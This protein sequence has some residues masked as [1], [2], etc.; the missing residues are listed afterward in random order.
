MG[1]RSQIRLGTGLP[2]L[3]KE[4][5]KHMSGLEE[6][7]LRNIDACKQ[8]SKIT[9]TSLGPNGMNKLVVN[10][11]D[12]LFVTSDTG[13]IVTELEVNHPAAKMVTMAAKMQESEVGDGTNFVV[14]FAGELLL[15]AEELLRQGIHISEIISGFEKAAEFAMRT[16]PELVC[17]SV[18]DVTDPAQLQQAVLPVMTAK[19]Y[20]YHKALSE[21]VSTACTKAMV[22]SGSRVS[23]NVDNVRVAKLVGG[24]VRDTTV[25]RGM[26]V[27]R[28]AASMV[29]RV[30]DAKVAVFGVG[31]EVSGTETKSTV[32]LRSA[33]E[34]LQYSKGEEK[35]IEDAVK[36]IADAGA[37]V[38]ISG[39]SISEMALHFVDK[40]NLMV[41]K[42]TSKFELRRLCRALGAV[43][44]VRLGPPMP[45]EM[46]HCHVVEEVE[47]GG[48]RVVVFRQED[49]EDGGQIAT[50]VLRGSTMNLLDDLERAVDDGVN[51]AKTAVQD[52][53]LVPGAG[54]TELELAHRVGEFAAG[55]PGL[56]QYAIRKFGEALEVVPR[57]LAVNAG[58]KA[59]EVIS[60]LYA[61]HASGK[62]SVGVDV[63]HASTMDAV[64]AG[65]FDLLATKLSAMRLAVDAAVTVLRVDQ[66]I[67]SKPAGGPK[68]PKP[69]PPDA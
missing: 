67:M 4:G 30:T 50:V 48:R 52:A 53:R 3:L 62:A 5:Y 64:E 38:I 6:A 54:A 32:V 36:G 21:V 22:K 15:H 55:T 9:A 35:M 14:S 27:Q 47:I 28:P 7:V 51:T 41:I 68:P 18:E 25:V 26:V 66:I 8:L 57:T 13:T 63:E 23:L 33:E 24:S 69:G 34:L 1:S 19:Q 46:G 42:V 65:V 29:K 12:K 43:A 49:G 10:H 40:Y 56:D 58:A 20:G 31:L 44:C 37:K 2:G 17:R 11:L 61:A 60:S 39:G 45:E 59:N 16:M